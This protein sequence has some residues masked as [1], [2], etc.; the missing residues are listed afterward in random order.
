MKHYR[1]LQTRKDLKD[2]DVKINH[3]HDDWKMLWEWHEQIEIMYVLSGVG[4]CYIEENV[5]TFHEG[6][7]FIIGPHKLHKTELMEHRD[8]TVLIVIFHLGLEN[9]F[10]YREEMDVLHFIKMNAPDYPAQLFLEKSVRDHIT[11]ILQSMLHEYKRKEGYSLGYLVSLLHILLIE[12]NRIYNNQ[13][14]SKRNRVINEV[15]LPK[16]IVEV[17]GYINQNFKEELSLSKLANTFGLSPSYLSR[18]FKQSTG[19]NVT[20]FIK[21]RRIDFAKNL[22]AKTN[23]NITEISFDVGFN[24]IAYFVSVFKEIVGMTPKQFR[25]ASLER[26]YLL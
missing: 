11:A 4:K 2:I 15:K 10:P 3:Q 17:I 22:L 14:V 21:S 7:L 13:V 16:T 19:I 1:Q 8:F 5:F 26:K 20:E 24:N 6:D 9:S 23:K 12:I 25:N 18:Q